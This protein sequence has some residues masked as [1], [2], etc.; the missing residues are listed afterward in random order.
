MQISFI[1]VVSCHSSSFTQIIYLKKQTLNLSINDYELLYLI[2]W[3]PMSH[4]GEYAAVLTAS[5]V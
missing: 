4:A 5:Y 3:F 2:K 1:E